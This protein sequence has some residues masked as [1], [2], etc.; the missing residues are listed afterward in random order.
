M[1]EIPEVPTTAEAGYPE[2]LASNW[3]ALAAPR[4]T[5]RRIIER[6]AAEVRGAL[7]D[8]ATRKRIAD[9]GMIPVGSTPAEFARHMRAEAERWKAVIERGGIKVQ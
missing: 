6:L 9:M 2:L 4:G 1:G 3:W 5:D 7:A 8:P